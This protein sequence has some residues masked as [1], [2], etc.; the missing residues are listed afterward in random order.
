MRTARTGFAVSGAAVIAAF[1]IAC[2][3]KP[4]SFTDAG[5]AD[6]GPP[7]DDSSVLDVS[8]PDAGNADVVLPVGEVYGH[9]ATTLFKL[10]PFSKTITTIGNFDC[11]NPCSGLLTGCGMWDIAI[12]E[13]GQMYGTGVTALN[14]LQGAGKLVKVDKATGHCTEIKTLGASQLYPN[15]LTFVPAGVLDPNVEVLVGYVNENYARIDLVTGVQTGIGSLNP[16]P[17]NT[18]WY[19]SGDIVS[20][21]GG[22]SFLTAKPSSD[23]NYS[24]TDTL[25]EIDPATGKVVKAIGDTTFTKLW[26]LAFWAGTAYGFSAAGQ[27]CAIDLTTGTGTPIP[28]KGIP[29]GLAWWGAG[30]TTVAPLLPPN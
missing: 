8:L 9:S 26:G 29:N 7:P 17:T 1:A 16:N 25:L 2:G 20:I 6:T 22:K 3:T 4:T 19:S 12:D 5:P 21:K 15:S 13:K 24:G 10:E 14:S 11:F 18:L 28:Q 30:V 23:P 27:L